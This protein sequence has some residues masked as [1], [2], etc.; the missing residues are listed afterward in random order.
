MSNTLFQKRNRCLQM[1][2]KKKMYLTFPH[3][4]LIYLSSKLFGAEQVSTLDLFELVSLK[5]LHMFLC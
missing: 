4:P 5:Q 2:W 3:Q 1:N